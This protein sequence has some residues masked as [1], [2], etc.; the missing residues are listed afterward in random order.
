MQ[1]NIYEKEIYV[2]VYLALTIK[3]VRDMVQSRKANAMKARHL[4]L[5]K[6]LTSD[7]K[8][9]CVHPLFSVFVHCDLDLRPLILL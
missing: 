1:R 3:N 5:Q 6:T 4:H 2:L 8:T 7:L 9:N